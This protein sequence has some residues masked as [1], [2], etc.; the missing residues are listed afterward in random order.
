L[1]VVVASVVEYNVVSEPRR[2]LLVEEEVLELVVL[3]RSRKL[4][5]M[6]GWF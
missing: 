6:V 5:M 1:D 2:E 4:L 3:P